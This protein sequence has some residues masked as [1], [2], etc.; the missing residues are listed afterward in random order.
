MKYV[1]IQLSL[2]WMFKLPRY[3]VGSDNAE[4]FLKALKLKVSLLQK[5]T[6]NVDEDFVSYISQVEGGWDFSF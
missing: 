6:G 3:I 5:S 1:I 4:Y 2:R